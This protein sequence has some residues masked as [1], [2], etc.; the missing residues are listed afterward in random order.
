MSAILGAVERT[1]REDTINK[2]N[3]LKF[4]RTREESASE[5]ERRAHKRTMTINNFRE[6]SIE[7][8]PITLSK[9]PASHRYFAHEKSSMLVSH[10]MKQQEKT[11]GLA[12][13][14]SEE[15][16]PDKKENGEKRKREANEKKLAIRA[17]RF[18]G[19]E[20]SPW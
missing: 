5:K 10:E 18:M 3:R 4:E 15:L 20:I 9:R 11:E 7:V 17:I 2:L 12:G 16:Q 19:Q 14:K 1:S 6:K 13:G 8:M